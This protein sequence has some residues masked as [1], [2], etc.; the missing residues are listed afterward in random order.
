MITARLVALLALAGT[1]GGLAIA[2]STSVAVQETAG[3]LALLFALAAGVVYYLDT[4]PS[5]LPGFA[6]D[7][8]P[9][10]A[11]LGPTAIERA[12]RG[13]PLEREALVLTLDAIERGGPGRAPVSTPTEEVRRIVALPRGAFREYVAARVGRLEH[14]L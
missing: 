14:D 2:V 5:P 10:F 13:D 9:A 6:G 8:E 12:L 7:P 11:R 4:T 3:V 1:A